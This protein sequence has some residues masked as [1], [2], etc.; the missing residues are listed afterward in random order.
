MAKVTRYE[1]DDGEH[2]FDTAVACNNYNMKIAALSSLDDVLFN[3]V[4]SAKDI[5]EWMT[6]KGYLK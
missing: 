5:I 3:R 6:V 2:V 1:S 4:L